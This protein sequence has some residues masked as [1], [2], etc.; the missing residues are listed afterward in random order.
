[1]KKIR[2]DMSRLS[3]NSGGF[4]IYLVHV[5]IICVVFCTE[6]VAG[7]EYRIGL[8]ADLDQSSRKGGKEL[9]NNISYFCKHVRE[10]AG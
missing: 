1:M 4:S 9:A 3:Q 6:T 5:R 8:V 7:M 2:L 10:K